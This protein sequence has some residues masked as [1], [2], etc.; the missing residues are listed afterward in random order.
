MSD[1]NQDDKDRLG[2]WEMFGSEARTACGR[3]KHAG[4]IC[5]WC[6]WDDQA[7]GCGLEDEEASDEN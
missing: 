6:G 2:L 5:P 3:L 4:Y 1:L 7:E